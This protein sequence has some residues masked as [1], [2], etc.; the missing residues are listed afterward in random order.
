M[1]W[2][3]A[4]SEICTRTAAFHN[5]FHRVNRFHYNGLGDENANDHCFN[6]YDKHNH[7]NTVSITMET[8]T[9]TVCAELATILDN[10][11]YTL[12]DL[13]TANS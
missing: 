7:C 2:G 10:N 3:S 11:G 12:S 1:L 6:K 13:G 5:G 9:I 8:T 4:A